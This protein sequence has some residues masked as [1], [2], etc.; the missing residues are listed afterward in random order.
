MPCLLVFHITGVT[1]CGNGVVSTSDSESETT[2]CQCWKT[3]VAILFVLGRSG[4]HGLEKPSNDKS[5]PAH[6]RFLVVLVGSCFL[7][8]D[9][10]PRLALGC[11]NDSYCLV[12]R[13]DRLSMSSCNIV[14][15][16]YKRFIIEVLRWRGISGVFIILIQ[17]EAAT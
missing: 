7:S 13:R 12:S 14:E 10:E 17:S 1:I 15:S 8:Q 5:S 3:E 4:L 9:G 16:S 11:K 6:R 2:Q